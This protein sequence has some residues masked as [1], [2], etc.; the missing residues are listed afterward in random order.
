MTTVFVE[1]KR[2]YIGTKTDS[3]FSHIER[4]FTKK[5]CE[6]ICDT[7]KHKLGMNVIGVYV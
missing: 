5:M 1:I 4:F 6:C 3:F 2:F 7:F